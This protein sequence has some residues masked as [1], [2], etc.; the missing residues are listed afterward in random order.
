MKSKKEI[1][2]LREPLCKMYVELHD[3][4][5]FYYPVKTFWGYK[6]DLRMAEKMLQYKILISS[7]IKL[8][9]WITEKKGFQTY[10]SDLEDLRDSIIE[11]KEDPKYEKFVKKQNG[12]KK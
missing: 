10:Q 6:G 11:W 12:E 5:K 8:I 9:D 2:E 3:L 1:L 7:Q 4:F